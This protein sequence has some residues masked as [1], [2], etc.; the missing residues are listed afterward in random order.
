MLGETGVAIGSPG[1]VRRQSS[2][3]RRQ[4]EVWGIREV[5]KFA[6]IPPCLPG[7]TVSRKR[8]TSAEPVG[9]TRFWRAGAGVGRADPA[10]SEDPVAT[11]RTMADVPFIFRGMFGGDELGKGGTGGCGGLLC[12][13]WL[14][15]R[16]YNRVVIPEAYAASAGMTWIASIKQVLGLMQRGEAC[17][18][19]SEEHALSVNDQRPQRFCFRSEPSSFFWPLMAKSQT[20]DPA[21]VSQW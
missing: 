18:W 4:K 3:E 15:I 21:A 1:K 2:C 7:S 12:R 10:T 8:E 9:N 20:Q 13:L 6:F 11:A 17:Y 14:Y 5:S 19:L 16:N